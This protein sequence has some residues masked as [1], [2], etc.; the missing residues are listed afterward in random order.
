MALNNDRTFLKK[1]S[2]MK[3][4]IAFMTL[5]LVTGSA[6]AAVFKCATPNGVIYSE[7]P[8]ASEAKTVVN[9]AKEPSEAEVRSANARLRNN[10]RE[11]AD[12]ERQEQAWR[13]GDQDVVAERAPRSGRRRR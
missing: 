4:L 10:M 6:G 13:Q 11:V 8:C 2:T 5:L 1:G 9:L 12:K 7:R 3:R